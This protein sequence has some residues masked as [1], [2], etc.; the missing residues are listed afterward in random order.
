MIQYSIKDLEQLTGIKAHTI[1]IWEKRYQLIEPERTST[2]IR[3]YSD[4]DLKKLLNVSTLNRNGLKISSIVNMNSDEINER[5]LEISET[6]HDS[7]NQIEQ[8]IIAMIDLDEQRFERVLS[9]SVIKLGFDETVVRV[10]YPFFE[11]IGLL[12]QIGTIYPAQEHFV[13]N[14]IRQKLI[15]AIDAQSAR[16]KTESK[17]F[18]LFLPSNEWHELGLL[19]YNYLLKKAGFKTIYLGQSVP[20]DDLLEVAAKHSVDYLLTSITTPLTL[21]K[22]A[23]YIHQLSDSFKGKTIF[24]TGYQTHEY[25]IELPQNVKHAGDP[26]SFQKSIQELLLNN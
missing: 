2:N 25:K 1:R 18:M 19:F 4:N 5:I 26:T 21:K 22:Y 7:D 23:E 14:L 13:S 12:W 15:I 10:L 20:F 9:T 24:I 6:S 17:S 8:L 3:F 11:K 16:F